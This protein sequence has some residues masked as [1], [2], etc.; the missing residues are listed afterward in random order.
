MAKHIQLTNTMREHI[1][2]MLMYEAAKPKA[3]DLIARVTD[4]ND[5][6]WHTHVKRLAAMGITSDK[7]PDLIVN[8]VC[9]SVLTAIPCYYETKSGQYSN[10]RTEDTYTRVYEVYPH[11]GLHALQE[12]SVLVRNLLSSD[13]FAPLSKFITTEYKLNYDFKLKF[14]ASATMP[15]IINMSV[16]TIEVA[17]IHQPMGE[18]CADINEVIRAALDFR[19]QALELLRACRTSKQL[20]ELFPEA[21]RFLPAKAQEKRQDIAPVE[22]AANVRSMLNKGVP[23]VITK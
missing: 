22:L 5:K 10:S 23:P 12:R 8:G 14:V 9:T 11:S 13:A 1:A 19:K 18:L 3:A 4:L 21:M 20:E 15:R 6:F 16:K 2:S 7:W 17:G